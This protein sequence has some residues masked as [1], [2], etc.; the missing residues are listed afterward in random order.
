MP[1]LFKEIEPY[2][3]FAIQVSDLHNVYVE[4]VGNKNGLPII[5][6]HGGPGGGIEPKHRQ[7]FDPKK[8]RVILFDQRGC[9]KSTPFGELREN[10]TF[11]LVHDMEKIRQH[12]GIQKWHVFGGSWGSTLSLTYAIT[13]PTRVSSLILRGIFLVRKKEINWFYQHGANMF[14]PEEWEYFLAPI[15]KSERYDLLSAYHKRLNSI[16]DDLVK[17]AARA[18]SRWEG[19]TSKLRKDDQLIK[20]F[21]SDRFSYAFARIENHYFYNRAFFEDDNWILNNVKKI[22]HIPGT[23]VQGRYDMP[24]PPISAYELHKVWPKA[25]FMMIEEAGHSAG[26]PGIMN[27]LV[28]AT[29]K[30]AKI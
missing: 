3:T 25:E 1:G 23:I 13:H 28:D 7:Y 2:N 16:D 30:M 12:L 22:Q 14:Y 9:G 21:S 18:W 29:D 20:E 6:V 11:D 4:E 15:P 8:W 19:A 27:A 10:T 26:E 17:E 5:F 24:C